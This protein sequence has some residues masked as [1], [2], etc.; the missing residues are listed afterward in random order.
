M[1]GIFGGTQRNSTA[2]EQ[3]SNMSVQTSGYGR[4]IP[5]VYGRARV[6]AARVYHDDFTAHPHTGTQRTGKG[7]GG[8]RTSSTTYTYTAS[9]IL[10]LCE[11]PARVGRMWVDK[12]VHW[13]GQYSFTVKDGEAAQEPWL[14]LATRH[15]DKAAPYGSTCYVARSLYDLGTGGSLRNHSFEVTGFCADESNAGD[16]NPADVLFA[17]LTHPVH[18][19]GFP[20][21]AVA[22]L[23]DYRLYAREA[24][25][26]VS[27]AFEGQRQ[28]VEAVGNLL[29]CTNSIPIWSGGRL[30]VLP[31]GDLPV[32]AWSPNSTPL[33]A[34]GLDDFL[35]DGP[36]D[37]PV[38][39]TRRPAADAY[40]SVR[41]RFKDRAAGYADGIAEANDLAMQDLHGLRPAPDFNAEC[42]ASARA[43]QTL[44]QILLQRHVGLR[45]E[46]R[47]R[48]GWRYALLEPGDLVTLTDPGL[49]LDGAPV[50]IAEVEEDSEGELAVTAVEWP[51]GVATAVAHPPPPAG[52][53]APN[54]AADP[55][56]C[57]PPVIFEP[58][59][60]LTGGALRVMVGTSGGPEWGGCEI[61]ASRAGSAYGLIGRIVAPARHG[62]LAAALPAYGGANPDA[63]NALDVLMAPSSGALA[64][65]SGPAAD[66]W[67]TLSY[68]SGPSGGELLSYASAEL[69]APG[70]YTLTGLRRGLFS[71]PPQAHSGAAGVGRPGASF[72]RLDQAVA[73][74]DMGRWD[75][76]ETVWFKFPSYNRH[77]RALQDL[78]D[79]GAVEYAVKGYG[80]VTWA[81]PSSCA[82]ALTKEFPE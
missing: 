41:V 6:A 27:A 2:A 38:E 82:L 64:G 58:P 57:L 77:G 66:K 68:V 33:Y 31:L 12:E 28:G 46:Y 74:L 22:P 20:A 35:A 32:G 43:A 60:D 3:L 5:V 25:L 13:P 39:V 21:A 54:E 4:C 17:M 52:G 81:A 14:W 29:E 42:I 69:T 62:T 71:T 30:R 37:D 34:L 15:P 56:H 63:G 24:G 23:D 47:F 65:A 50:R 49:G 9:I 55:G 7:G 11:G 78:A 72:M 73:E 70:R 10:A 53:D 1:A 48:L 79:V 18:G 26:C 45:N 75:V 8:S 76:G 67:E 80:L 51:N 36:D 61:H 44:A 59:G 19:M 40:N 16:A